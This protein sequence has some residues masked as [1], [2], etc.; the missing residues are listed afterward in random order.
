MPCL[1]K[2]WLWKIASMKVPSEVKNV[3]AFKHVLVDVVGWK[4]IKK[5]GAYFHA[6]HWPEAYSPATSLAYYILHLICQMSTP[7]INCYPMGHLICPHVLF[8]YFH[9][10]LKW[11][12][13]LTWFFFSFL[14][15]HIG[16]M[17]DFFFSP[18]NK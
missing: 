17:M 8:F 6:S 10:E 5:R 13:L 7:L 14:T 15:F 2:Y 4:M 12:P 9:L 3:F 18:C 16:S 11:P 1:I